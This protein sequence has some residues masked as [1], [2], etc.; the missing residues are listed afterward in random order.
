MHCE[1]EGDCFP[2]CITVYM[3]RG[4]G[5]CISGK[6]VCIWGEGVSIWW[7]RDS[8]SEGRGR[9]SAS[10]GGLHPTGGGLHL[11][12][13]APGERGLQ[14]GFLHPEDRRI[15]QSSPQNWEKWAVRILL[16]CFLVYFNYSNSF[17]FPSDDF[18]QK[19]TFDNQLFP[20]IRHLMNLMMIIETI[21]LFGIDD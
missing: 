9:G 10:D 12:A 16:E 21:K 1:G 20:A 17:Q 15:P 11:G 5:V 3:T 19:N 6:G 7:E 4:E 2:A 8:A 13:S 14:L 18:V